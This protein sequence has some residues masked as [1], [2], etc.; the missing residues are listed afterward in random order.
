MA[1]FTMVLVYKAEDQ[2]IRIGYQNET[3]Y[4]F[5]VKGEITFNGVNPISIKGDLRPGSYGEFGQLL[6]DQINDYPHFEMEIERHSEKGHEET[7]LCK[8]KTKPKHFLKMSNLRHWDNRPGRSYTVWKPEMEK[9]TLKNIPTPKM[10]SSPSI[11]SSGRLVTIRDLSELA[12]F[13]REL[14]L[15]AEKLF[16]DPK[17]VSPE[18]IFN[19]QMKTFQWFMDKARSMNVERVFIIHG[20]G[21]GRLKNEIAKRLQYD[22]AVSSYTN[23]HHPKYGFGATEVVFY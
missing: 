20:I 14:D 13:T 12:V 11:A 4:R 23:E 17:S 8:I 1:E 10:K 18:V 21:S 6:F 9:N 22:P 7:F 19:K 15:H 16:K 3:V 2:K 5:V